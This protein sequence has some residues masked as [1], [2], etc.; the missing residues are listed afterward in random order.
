V[1]VLSLL[2]RSTLV[3]KIDW[4][5]SIDVDRRNNLGCGVAQLGSDIA[6]RRVKRSSVRV[7]R[8][9]MVSAPGYC[10]AGFESWPGNP[11]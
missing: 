3:P 6:Q 4:N 11:W 10:K 9:S 1:L 5:I 2:A 8:N 7:R